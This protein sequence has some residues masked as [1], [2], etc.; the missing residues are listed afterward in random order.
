MPKAGQRK[1]LSMR[2]LKGLALLFSFLKFD[3]D[4]NRGNT[5]GAAIYD[6]DDRFFY[7]AHLKGQPQS[8]H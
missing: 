8:H 5:E 2:I 7:S 1:D 4:D 3:F 6:D